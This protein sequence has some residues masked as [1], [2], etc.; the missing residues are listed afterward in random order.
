M[1]FAGVVEDGSGTKVDQFNNIRRSHNAVIEFEVTVGKSDGVEIF[2][3]VAY[4]AEYAV[5]LRPAHLATH[6]DAEE[7]KGGIFHDL[8]QSQSE[9]R[10]EASAALPRSNVHDRKQYPQSR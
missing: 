4:L 7:V 9:P 3:A 6:D 8:P 10:T 5:D 1:C 2:D